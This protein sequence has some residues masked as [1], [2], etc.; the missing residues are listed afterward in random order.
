MCKLPNEK[1][2]RRIDL[3]YSP[4]HEFPFALLYFTGNFQFNIDMRAYAASIGYVLNEHGLFD[5]ESNQSILTANTE[6]DIFT[7]LNHE[8]IEPKNRLHFL[9]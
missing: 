3:M 1:H 9:K 5:K 2:F 4:P 8:Y 7:F 6:E